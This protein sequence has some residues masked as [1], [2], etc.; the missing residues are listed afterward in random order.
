[1]P[2]P[3][4]WETQG[5][6]ARLLSPLGSLF[7]AAGGL[8][9][10]M[11]VPAHAKVPVICVGNLVAGG[12][13]KT[14][15][16]LALIDL[17]LRLGLTPH[18]LT[19]GYGGSVPGPVA[20][21]SGIHDA[22]SVGDEALLL[23]AKAPTWVARN[24]RAGASAI[25][26]AGGGVILMDD[27]MQNPT[28]HHDWDIL[29]VDGSY[30]F[31]NGRLMPA[32]PLRETIASGLARSRFAVLIGNDRHNLESMLRSHLPVLQAQVVPVPDDRQWLGGRVVAFAGIGR[33]DKFFATLTAAGANIVA[34]QAFPDHHPYRRDQIASLAVQATAAGATLV[35]TEKDWVRLPAEY[36]ESVAVLR[37]K[38]AWDADSETLLLTALADLLIPST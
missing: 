35:T 34:R 10:R 18:I 12:A 1:M 13:G 15:V 27:G 8:R 33:P 24:R 37:V 29:V 16:V 36:R 9:R 32:G 3:G 4:F 17:M 22:G 31:G 30:G 20:V 11:T 14:P 28:L 25:A 23:A 7:G 5:L 2:A 26:A 38:L 21:D 6:P 19:R